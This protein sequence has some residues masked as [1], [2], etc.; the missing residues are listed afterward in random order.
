MDYLF[1]SRVLLPLKVFSFRIHLVDINVHNFVTT[2]YY[3]SFN[4]V[5]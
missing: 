5:K 3:N 1:S 2:V 4:V